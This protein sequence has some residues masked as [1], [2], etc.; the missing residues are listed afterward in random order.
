MGQYLTIY[1]NK[2]LKNKLKCLPFK[3][4][5]VFYYSFLNWY[6]DIQQSNDISEETTWLIQHVQVNYHYYK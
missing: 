6:C 3:D 5:S 2:L 4:I 1:L